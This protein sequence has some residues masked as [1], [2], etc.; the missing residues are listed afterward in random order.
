MTFID[1][2]DVVALLLEFEHHDGLTFVVFHELNGHRTW[3][4]FG[5]DI[6]TECEILLSLYSA[7]AIFAALGLNWNDELLAR[8]ANADVE[9]VRLDLSNIGHGR[10]QVALQRIGHHA[11]EQVDQPVAMTSRGLSVFTDSEET[12]R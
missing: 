6:A 1:D 11:E 10:P 3:S 4:Q 5:K 12:S 2:E 8:I 9:F 7:D